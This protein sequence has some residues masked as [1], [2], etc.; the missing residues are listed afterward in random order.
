[1]PAP[2]AEAKALAV[3]GQLHQAKGEPA[4][5]RER[6]AEARAI[7]TRQGERLYAQQIGAELQ[8]IK[9]PEMHS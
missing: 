8:A 5:A 2:Y 4:L 1:M 6:F 7:C 3:Y 9:Q